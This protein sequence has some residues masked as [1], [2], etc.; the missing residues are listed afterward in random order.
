MW[1]RS[2]S[3]AAIVITSKPSKNVAVPISTRARICIAF[4]GSRS[5]R[6][7]I[8]PGVAALAAASAADPPATALSS[9]L[10]RVFSSMLS[11]SS[12]R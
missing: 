10:M 1:I 3:V 7:M 2:G 11:F 6:A 4:A 5:R 9:V 12:I 8:A